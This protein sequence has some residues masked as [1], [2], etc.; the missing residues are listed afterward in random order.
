[1]KTRKL[2][3]NDMTTIAVKFVVMNPKTSLYY[4]KPNTWSK[5]INDATQYIHPDWAIEAYQEDTHDNANGLITF[6]VGRQN[7]KLCAVNYALSYQNRLTQIDN[8]S[9]ENETMLY[10]C[11]M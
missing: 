2:L 10:E 9:L 1:M 4:V 8:F 3:L 6:A 11:E 7:N 5:D